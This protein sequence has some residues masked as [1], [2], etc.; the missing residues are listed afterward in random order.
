MGFFSF[1]YVW[2]GQGLNTASERSGPSWVPVQWDHFRA[3]WQLP[4]SFWAGPDSQWDFLFFFFFFLIVFFPLLLFKL[5]GKL[6]L[7]WRGFYLC[8]LGKPLL[9]SGS[10]SSSSHS[11]ATFGISVHA[12]RCFLTGTGAFQRLL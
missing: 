1:P 2:R 10:V 6:Q 11:S 3:G 4:N 8:S 9:A 7:A 5:E 12:H